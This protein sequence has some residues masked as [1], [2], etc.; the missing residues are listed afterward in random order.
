MRNQP[1]L[2]RSKPETSSTRPPETVSENLLGNRH[3]QRKPVPQSVDASSGKSSSHQ[4]DSDTDLKKTQVGPTS[5]LPERTGDVKDQNDKQQPVSSPIKSGLDNPNKPTVSSEREPQS[6]FQRK[7]SG[8]GASKQ[9]ASPDTLQSKAFGGLGQQ[10]QQRSGQAVVDDKKRSAFVQSTAS[11]PRTSKQAP[12]RILVTV[13]VTPEE[14]R[15]GPSQDEASRE[16][17]KM[18]V[19]EKVAPETSKPRVSIQ[20]SSKVLGGATMEHDSAPQSVTPEG[21]TKDKEDL[22]RDT[23]GKSNILKGNTPS[24]P[25]LKTEPNPEPK[26][27]PKPT[28]LSTASADSTVT[29]TGSPLF[30]KGQTTPLNGAPQTEGSEG[31]FSDGQD[32]SSPPR[33]PIVDLGEEGEVF[34]AYYESL[35]SDGKKGQADEQTP[36]H[37]AEKSRPSTDSSK[38]GRCSS[39]SK[40][41]RPDTSH[42][43]SASQSRGNQEHT[44]GKSSTQ[45]ESFD[46]FEFVKEDAGRSP[47]GVKTHPHTSRPST[48]HY[49][50]SNTSQPSSTG[51]SPGSASQRSPSTSPEDSRHKPSSQSSSDSGRHQPG[52]SS[53]Y[54]RNPQEPYTRQP[55]KPQPQPQ[56]KP[57]RPGNS[58]PPGPRT[59]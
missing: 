10:S 49:S 11:S 3:I 53:S 37:P 56:Y 25:R 17:R 4:A 50:S 16:S 35:R 47:P 2:S 48:N 23:I 27:E 41:S 46:R 34:R 18:T 19:S 31:K 36:C 43:E 55:P 14:P 26:P 39:G 58:P 57:Y 44:R 51:F 15:P 21:L 32:R 13:N 8:D 40:Q 38:P 29:E 59:F 45:S 28:S 1:V 52:T 6:P 42:A 30:G 7:A 22:E 20:P 12:R 54:G 33:S 9:P 24:T 5:Q